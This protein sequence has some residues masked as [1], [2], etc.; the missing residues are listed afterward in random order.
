MDS[1]VRFHNV[2]LRY[3][4]V[5]ALDGIDLEIRSGEFFGI[6]GP[7]GSGKTSCLRLIAGFDR[8]SEGAIELHGRS[9]AGVPPYDRDVNTVFQDYALFPHMTIEQNVA[10]GLMVKGVERRERRIRVREIL[11]MVRLEGLGERRPNQ[12]SGGQR[13]R[14]A[15]AR[16]LVNQPRVLLLDEPLGALDLKLRQQ[17]QVELRSLQRTLGITF[18]FVTHDQGEALSMSD[19]L[20]VFNR[21]RIEQIG[22][23]QEIYERPSTRFA[24]EFVG[25]S[26]IV[27]RRDSDTPA[28]ERGVFSLRPEKVHLST[29]ELRASDRSIAVAGEVA[30][31]QFHGASVRYV[32]SLPDASS[33][34]AV[35]GN[36]GSRAEA[37]AVRSGTRVWL[38]WNLDDLH[39]LRESGGH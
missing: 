6:L 36:L 17:M 33:M 24:A 3:A 29:R 8:P 14:V 23:P 10:F 7:S 2:S 5:L 19:R 21:G 37:P 12:L 4:R 26:N 11:E 16:V 18:I 25:D 31:V 13:Q 38:N 1:A 20:A 30:D 35:V 27:E 28:H 22:T 9:V 32:V 15:L 34:T 39:R